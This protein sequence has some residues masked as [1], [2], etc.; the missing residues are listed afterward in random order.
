MLNIIESRE[1]LVKKIDSIGKRAGTLSNDIADAAASAFLHAA[2]TGD[3]TLASKLVR[4]VS[5]SFRTDLRRY[6]THFGPVVWDKKS[7]QFKKVKKGGAYDPA[8]LETRFDAEL[9][10]AERAARPYDRKAE[11]AKMIRELD[12]HADRA[13]AAGDADMVNMLVDLAAVIGGQFNV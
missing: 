4:K 8:A 6:F 10:N 7:Q 11:L 2:E 12:V 5:P 3:L 1:D 13:V 9:P